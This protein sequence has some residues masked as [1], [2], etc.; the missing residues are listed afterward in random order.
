MSPDTVNVSI[1]C[2]PIFELGI[3]YNMVIESIDKNCKN[4][5]IDMQWVEHIHSPSLAEIIRIYVHLKN[6]GIQLS[7]KSLNRMNRSILEICRLDNLI[8]II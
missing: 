8:T 2:E 7:L 6:E 4:V 5:C 3:L 1:V